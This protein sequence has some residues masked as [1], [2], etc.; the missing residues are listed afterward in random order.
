MYHQ[1]SDR[2]QGLLVGLCSPTPTIN[3]PDDYAEMERSILEIDRVHPP[4]GETV[5]ILV[6]PND[7]PRPNATYRRR[8]AE[9]RDRLQYPMI[10]C[11]ISPSP[12]IRSVV[13][14]V[15]WISPPK[16]GAAGAYATVEEAIVA[17]E[18]RLRQKLP[19][20]RALCAEVTAVR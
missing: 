3:E 19:S 1:A 8:F 12:I 6:V 15:N 9:L 5:Y 11:L 10:F 16:V 4:M 18:K 13:T 20:L 7:W 17:V 14:A 2:S